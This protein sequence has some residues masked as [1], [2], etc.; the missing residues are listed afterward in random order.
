MGAW[1]VLPLDFH[2]GIANNRGMDAFCLH[3]RLSTISRSFVFKTVRFVVNVALVASTLFILGTGTRVHAANRDD[4]FVNRLTARKEA[5]RLQALA[6]AKATTQSKYQSLPL[7]VRAAEELNAELELRSSLVPSHVSIIYLIGTIDR[8]EA[9]DALV[10]MLKCEHPDVVTLASDTLG[11]NKF[12]GSIDRIAELKNSPMFDDH[13]GFRFNLIRSLFEMDDP[14]AIELITKW[15]PSLGGQL[16]REVEKQLEKTDL[17]TFDNDAERYAKWQ[18]SL[19]LAFGNPIENLEANESAANQDGRP[20]KLTPAGFRSSSTQRLELV[21][22]SQFYGMDIYAKRMM[23]I[24]DH[25]GSMQEYENGM[26]RLDRAK[27]ELIKAI[28]GLDSK[29]EFA[30]MVYESKVNLWRDEL[31]RATDEEKRYAIRYVKRL[32][33]GNR[34]NT[35]GALVR[36]LSFDSQLEAVYLL[37]DGRPTEGRLKRP[38]LIIDDIVMKNRFRHLHFNAIGIAVTTTTERFLQELADASGGQFRIAK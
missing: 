10:K 17:A 28:E 25:S 23:F 9:E 36:S 16:K 22:K 32:G 15:L 37:T 27:S 11:R 18:E 13:Y 8:P 12:R 6:E 4:R 24:I 33:Y 21:N 29:A 2:W 20:L 19:D 26:T 34:T 5:V 14:N 1:S 38:G 31:T 30:I 3:L 7:L 35:H